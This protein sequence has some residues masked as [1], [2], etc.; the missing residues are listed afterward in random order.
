MIRSLLVA[1]DAGLPAAVSAQVVAPSPSSAPSAAPTPAPDICSTG[2]SAIITR[3]TQTTSACVVK[4]N[5]VLI[6]TGYQSQTVDVSG[7]SF[8]YQTVPSGDMRTGTMLENVE[9]DLFPPSAIASA[10]ETATSDIGASLKWQIHSIPSFAYGINV[11]ATASTG[12]NPLTNP[13]GLGR[14]NASTYTYNL[15]IQGSLGRIFG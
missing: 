6:E 15:N 10:R 1:A 2:I 13:N 5:H 14:A 3:P 12:S 11:S 7:G 9:L 8:T 4:P